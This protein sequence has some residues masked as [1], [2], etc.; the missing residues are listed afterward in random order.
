MS[1]PSDSLPR[2][3]TVQP[4]HFVPMYAKRTKIYARS[5]R[6]L[7]ARLR[8]VIVVLTQSVFFGLPWLSWNGRQ[9]VL[10][11]L[12][13]PRF[14]VFGLVLQP[15]DLIFLAGLLLM[16]ALA[17]LLT[18]TEVGADHPALREPSTFLV[19]R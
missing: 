15:Q 10:F 9:A 1:I 7:Y 5:V 19:P 6:G 16:A 17:L 12:D 13:A 11:D 8:W 4:V 14:Y 2:T 3:A 18:L